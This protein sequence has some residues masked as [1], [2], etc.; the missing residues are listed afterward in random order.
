[1]R[2]VTPALCL[3]G[4]L[5]ACG[6]WQRV[7]T[8]ARPGP[9]AALPEVFEPRA[10]YRAMGLA[11]GGDALPFV[12]SLYSFAG[13]TPDS[14]PIVFA[15]SLANHA[16]SF[17]RVDSGYVAGYRVELALRTDSNVAFQVERNETV[18]VRSFQ[19]TLRSDE[20]IIFEQAFMGRPGV[21]A[22][23]VVVRDRNGPAFGE[24]Q[25]VA[26]VRRR[27]LPGLGSPVPIYAGTG[28]ARLAAVPDLVVNPRAAL[29]YGADSLLF[30]VEGYGLPAGTRLAA[31][32]LDPDSVEL[33]HDTL[34]LGEG[35]VASVRFAVKPRDLPVG[36]CEFDV[37][38]VGA[39]AHVG[40][41]FLVTFSDV[42]AVM[43]FDQMLDL[44]RYFDQPDLV[45]K[46][47][48]APRAQRAAAWRDFYTASDPIPI[49]PENE[50]LDQYVHRVD[51]ANHRFQ[52]PGLAGWQ[53][54]RGEVFITLGDPDGIAD[55]ANVMTTTGIHF[56]QWDYAS[57]RLT[58]VFQDETGFGQFRLTPLSRSEYQR[59]LARV[60]RSR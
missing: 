6:S 38:E 10:L 58:L 27:D 14:T 4:L 51:M 23:K 57:L 49:T 43:N 24:G 5:T 17:R 42:W 54:E 40:T 32:V 45:A 13:P 3:A 20:S 35:P 60:R 52:E 55:A 46:L 28:R 36:R 21:Y 50:A 56:I 39:A 41:P 26:T 16:L 44:L 59:V 12:A 33:W 18:R 34:A 1:M 53:T 37:R 9:T 7:G 31:R 11:V 25:M 8:P 19:E 29:A 22:L 48:A 47:K 15:L 30:Y 2:R